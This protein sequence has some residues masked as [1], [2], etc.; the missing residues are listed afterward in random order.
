[1]IIRR[2]LTG[3]RCLLLPGPEGAIPNCTAPQAPVG[4]YWWTLLT[5]GCVGLYVFVIFGMM[6]PRVRTAWV[7]G[8][9]GE[10]KRAIWCVRVWIAFFLF[11]FFFSCFNSCFVFLL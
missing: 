3:Y 6:S 9:E 2:F 8:T 4:I 11:S 5:F 1:M 10:G 7:T